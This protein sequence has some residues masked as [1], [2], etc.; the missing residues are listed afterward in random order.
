MH[1]LDTRVAKLALLDAHL[2][3]GK[4][5][6]RQCYKRV[7]RSDRGQRTRRDVAEEIRSG[8]HRSHACADAERDLLGTSN[9]AESYS[10]PDR[11]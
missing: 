2:M 8:V 3:R 11:Q 9:G 6:M 4:L 10:R 5:G 7:L 1:L